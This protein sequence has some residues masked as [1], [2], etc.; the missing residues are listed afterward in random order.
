MSN[1]LKCDGAITVSAVDPSAVQC[2]VG[3]LQVDEPVYTLM[4]YEQ[5]SDLVVTLVLLWGLTRAF[6][7]ILKLMGF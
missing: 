6:Q 2:S 4:T 1:Y 5:A 7:I 3:F